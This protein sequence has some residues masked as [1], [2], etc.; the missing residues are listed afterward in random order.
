MSLNRS[1]RVA[2]ITIFLSICFM[3]T[4]PAF[5]LDTPVA[6]SSEMLNLYQ[7]NACFNAGT[8]YE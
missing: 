7:C 5:A 4:Q 8:V 1:I 6:C 3:T 2:G